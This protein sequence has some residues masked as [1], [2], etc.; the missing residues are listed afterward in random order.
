MRVMYF[1]IWS[2]WLFIATAVTAEEWKC[3]VLHLK[4]GQVFPGLIVEEGPDRVL[5]QHILRRPGVRTVT[6]ELS[7]EPAEIDHIDRLDEPTRQ[8]LKRKLALLDETGEQEKL[9]LQAV[10]FTKKPWPGTAQPALHYLGKYFELTSN[11]RE[12]LV[13]L[14]VVRLEEVFAAYVA[15][16]GTLRQTQGR[17]KV[18]LYRSVQE[19][20]Q[21]QAKRG[22]AL[23]NTAYYDPTRNEIFLASDLER[24]EEELEKVRK[25]HDGKLQELA[26][27][28]KKLRKHYHG[29]PPAASLTQLR[30]LRRQLQALN[31]ENDAAMERLRSQF[32]ATLYHEAF[33]AYLDT[34][35]YPAGETVVPRW[36]NEGLAQIFETALVET[37]ELRVGHVDPE[38]LAFVQGA[39]KKK[40]LVPVRELLLATPQDFAV[41]HGADIWTADRHYL[42]S[43]ALAYYLTFER[44]LMGTQAMHQYVRTQSSRADQVQLFQRLTGQALDDFEKEFHAYLLLL[45]PDGS[46]RKF[47]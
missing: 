40:E 6:R 2:S 16:L 20:Q 18:I 46:L 3:E 21:W 7:V 44:K 35:V 32:F 9:R 24:L 17:T 38:R 12:E 27:Q 31:H 5:F 1:L 47:K 10:K 37:G 8:Q 15:N 29:K 28:D 42:T 33:H 25:K 26:E 41:R 14:A 23:L 4:S 39:V 45:R 36:L 13:R 34:Y 11:A 19:Y 43:W 22:L 30:H